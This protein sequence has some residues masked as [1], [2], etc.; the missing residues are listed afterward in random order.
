MPS[1]NPTQIVL[2]TL[3]LGLLSFG[4]SIAQQS[5][6]G[7]LAGGVKDPNGLAVSNATVTATNLGTGAKRTAQTNSDG[8]WT[9]TTLALGE[10]QVTADAENFKQAIQKTRVSASSTTTV[11]LTL[12]I[13]EQKGTV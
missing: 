12:G 3:L 8:R 9:I 13:A 7:S 6:N 4:T 2:V 11:D 5:D 10:Y 1:N